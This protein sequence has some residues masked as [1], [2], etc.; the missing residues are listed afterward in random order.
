MR[1]LARIATS[2][3]VALCVGLSVVV[4]AVAAIGVE[5]ARWSTGLGKEIAGN[6][7]A[8]STA[9]GEL[10]RN[11][12]TA[13][14]TGEEA[15]LTASPALR[16]HS[17][18]GF[19]RPCC[20]RPTRDDDS[21]A[22]PREDPP[23]EHADIERLVRQW[24]AVR[25]LLSPTSWRPTRRPCSRPTWPPRTCRSASTSTGSSSRSKPTGTPTRCG[26][27]RTRCGPSGSSSASPSPASWSADSCS[28]AAYGASTR[29][30]NR[31]RTRR[32]SPIRCRS[33]TTRTRR[34]CSFSAT[35][36]GS[37]P[38]RPPPWC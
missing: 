8:T 26:R 27:P 36:S 17:S 30:C 2:S 3:L 23:A 9:T 6:E 18:A 11:M 31:V 1:N 21:G 5:G 19:T 24:V 10:A 25:D 34:T 12:D 32:N 35:W 37:S 20:P 4:V 7:L 33:R 15:F 16:S 13:Y 22:T 29:P 38:R 28:T 14:A